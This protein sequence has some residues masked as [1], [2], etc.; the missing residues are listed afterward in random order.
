MKAYLH[1]TKHKIFHKDGRTKDF[2]NC[3]NLVHIYVI[4]LDL[5]FQATHENLTLTYQYRNE[6]AHFYGQA[7]NAVLF[8]LFA[9]CVLNSPTS[10]A[11]ILTAS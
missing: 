8:G 7:M 9:E 2:P 11:I 10:C 1:K 3:L 4:K 5:T 6:S